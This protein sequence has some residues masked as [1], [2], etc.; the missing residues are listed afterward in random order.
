MATVHGGTTGSV[1]HEYGAA[2]WRH[3]RS[4]L[5]GVLA[6][7]VATVAA[8]LDAG[9]WL[10]VAVVALVGLF[11]AQFQA[12]FDMRRERDTLR[13]TMSDTRYGF[14]VKRVEVNVR[15]NP[16]DGLAAVEV[17]FIFENLAPVPLAY[18]VE[19]VMLSVDGHAAPPGV[20]LPGQVIVRGG[21]AGYTTPR[22]PTGQPV[23]QTYRGEASITVIYG[24]PDIPDGEPGRFRY[25]ISFSFVYAQ[26]VGQPTRYQFSSRDIISPRHDPL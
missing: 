23:R 25:T 3:W 24:H 1:V 6:L 14:G 21:E 7:A 15:V 13:V 5:T 16:D 17:I 12:W 2:L 19:Q 10:P 9:W 26:L 11:V 20:G 8:A 18:H 22:I 4:L